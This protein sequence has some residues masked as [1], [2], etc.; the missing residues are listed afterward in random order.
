MQEALARA[1]SRVEIL[2]GQVWWLPDDLLDL[3]DEAATH[4]TRHRQRPIVVMQ[5]DD[6]LRNRYC[7][8]VVVLPCSSNLDR[9]EEW[10][11]TLTT[12]ETVLDGP[13]VVKLQLIQPV[14]RNT[15][16]TRGQLVGAL[17]PATLKRIQIHLVR[18][19]GIIPS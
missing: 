12:D 9:K 6:V 13:S 5:G 18:N 1:Q 3:G 15:L 8:T 11:D 17:D 2:A 4:R 16:L 7:Q 19:L 10:E 14:N